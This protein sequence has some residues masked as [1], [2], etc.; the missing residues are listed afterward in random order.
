LRVT[1]SYDIVDLK[2][3]TQ[4]SITLPFY[5]SRSAIA[6]APAFTARLDP[7]TGVMNGNT[8]DVNSMYNGLVLTIRKPMRNGVEVLANYTF[9]KATDNGQQSG[10]NP[11]TEGQVGIPAIDP[12]NNK[13]EKGYSGTDIRNRFSASVIVAPGWGNNAAGAMRLLLGG[14]SL[15]STI[16][17]QSGQAYTGMVQGTT[18]PN[19]VYNGY[20]PGSSTLTMFTYIPLD[21]SMGGAGITS[22][23]ANLAGR[24]AWLAPGSFKLPSLYDV[25][26]RLSKQFAITERYNIELRAEAFNVFNSTLVQQ[27]SQNAY[28]Y[29]S[30]GSS[31]CPATHANTCMAPVTSFRQY[32]T[33]SGNLFGARQLQ[34]GIRFRF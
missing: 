14:W 12:F 13:L 27:V 29:V 16:I 33:T 31:G 9:S 23:G 25:D 24:I 3:V 18:A 26:L 21:G 30:P 8:S 6:G 1:K 20:A 11:M 4:Q 15:S 19:A 32:Q 7:R 5:S 34:A 2:G 28:R 22:P 17:A 10:G